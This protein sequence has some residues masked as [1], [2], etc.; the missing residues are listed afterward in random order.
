M[1]KKVFLI[2]SNSHSGVSKL[3]KFFS[4]DE[5]THVAISLSRELKEMYSFGRLHANLPIPG[6]FVVEDKNG[7]FY[8]RF[9]KTKV[10]IL[11]VDVTEEQFEQIKFFINYHV[12]HK[13]SLKYDYFGVL[14]AY[15]NKTRVISNRKYCSQFVKDC[16]TYAKVEGSQTLP[17]VTRPIH[18][19]NFQN[20]VCIYE[21]PLKNYN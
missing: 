4:H 17:K 18:F 15:F 20:S 11:E 6:G 13:K 19:D 12:R 1:C 2:L 5:Y 21:G 3:L 10:K 7:K 14:L 16:L 8:T 9:N